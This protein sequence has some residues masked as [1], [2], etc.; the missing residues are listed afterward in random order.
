MP[1]AALERLDVV[2]GGA[3]LARSSDGT[4]YES[5]PAW[6]AMADR[7]VQQRLNRQRKGSHRRV[8]TKVRLARLYAGQR[9]LR[10]DFLH[11][12][13]VDLVRRAG[14]ISV[15]AL[16]GAEPERERPA[17]DADRVTLRRMLA[18]KCERYGRVLAA[19]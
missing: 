18:Y 3:A 9:N 8:R 12:V 4:E 5:P 6:S 10:L 17:L 7:R 11:K 14:V 19:D 1:P 2:A 15:E 16:T 13:S